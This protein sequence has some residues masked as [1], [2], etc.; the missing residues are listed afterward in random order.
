[1]RRGVGHYFRTGLGGGG[2]AARRLGGTTKTAARLFSALSS[3]SA[4]TPGPP[5]IPV[6][7]ALLAGRSVEQILDVVTDAVRPVDGSLDAEANRRAIRD[8]LSE[9]LRRHPDAELE[10]LD[11]AQRLLAVE[12]FVANDVFNRLVAD[13]GKAIKAAASS[14]AQAVSRLKEIYSYIREVVAQ[15]FRRLTGDSRNISAARLQR[16]VHTT[17]TDAISVFESYST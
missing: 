16:I 15:E 6:D 11:E 7:R 2:T 17:L 1:M 10:H 4:G 14:T 13:I 3:L 12:A 8:A 9:V 5:G